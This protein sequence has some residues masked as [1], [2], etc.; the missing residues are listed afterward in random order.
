MSEEKRKEKKEEEQSKP[1]DESPFRRT[2]FA[3]LQ[4][5]NDIKPIKAPIH[6]NHKGSRDSTASKS[7]TRTA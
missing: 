3:P 4:K 2:D 6:S 7:I 1:L 5:L